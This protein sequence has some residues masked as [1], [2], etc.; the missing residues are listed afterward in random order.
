LIRQGPQVKVE[1]EGNDHFFDRTLRKQITVFEGG[2]FDEF[3]LDASKQKLINFY[4]RRGYENVAVEWTREF[5]KPE[6]EAETEKGKEVKKPPRSPIWNKWVE[7]RREVYGPPEPPPSDAKEPATKRYRVTFKI[8]EGPRRQ[9]KDIEF[10]GNENIKSKK[11]L[12]LMATKKSGFGEKGYYLE[13]LFEEDLRNIEKF[14]QAEGYPDAEIA[15]WEKLYSR[16]GDGV[17]LQ[18]HINEGD[19]A[20]VQEVKLEGVPDEM[21]KEIFPTLLLQNGKPY[22]EYLLSQDIQSILVYLSDEGYPYAQIVHDVQ[23]VAPHRYNVT[24]QT[25]T[26]PQVRIGR[27]LF[28][29]NT[30]TRESIIR[31]NLRIKEGDLFSTTNILQSQINLRG[32]G[33]FDA[34]NLETLGL[35]SQR[36]VVNL[37][38]R[39]QEKKPKIIDVEAGYSTDLGFSGKLTFNKLNMWGSGKNGNIQAQVGNQVN[40][41]EI[42]YIDPRVYGTGLQLVLGVFGGREDRPFFESTRVGGFGNLSKSFGPSLTAY[43]RLGFGFADNN[44]RDTVFESIN[45]NPDPNQSTRLQTS[46]GTT[47]DTRDNFGNPRRGTYLNGTVSLTNEFIQ[48]SGNYFT[49]RSNMGYW[50]SPFSRFTIANALRVAQIISVPGDTIVP[51]DARLYLGGDSTVRGFD[52]DSLLPSGGKFSLVWN[53]EFQMRVFGNFQLVGFTDTGVVTDSITQVSLGTLRHSAGPGFR[54]MTPVG[55][56]RLDYGFVLDP[57]NSDPTDHR[58]HFS[59]GYFF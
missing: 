46:L 53:L 9:V 55:P 1:F 31:Q 45:P 54:Y 2:D 59:F 44:D 28:V 10:S 41:L 58:L 56:I 29:G 47:Y 51:T 24:F 20:R 37:V 13:P 49:L 27:L 11:L 35:T 43:G 26:G 33:V 14:Y 17:T 21:Q 38:V 4:Q 48:R 52:E 22:S 25:T 18:V 36:K 12:K 8:Q 39:V 5:I 7:L 19:L 30:L 15:S 16:H 42:N 34:V 50:Y 23:E 40:Q 32:L 3:E 6:P 57:Q